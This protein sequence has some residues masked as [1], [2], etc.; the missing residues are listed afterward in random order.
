MMDLSRFRRSG[1]QRAKEVGADQA[2]TEWQQREYKLNYTPTYWQN[3]RRVAR[4]KHVID[5]VPE[6]GQLPEW[7]DR[8]GVNAAYEYMKA[9]HNNAPWWEWNY[10]PNDDLALEPLGQLAAPPDDFLWPNEQ[11]YKQGQQIAPPDTEQTAATVSPENMP[12]NL[13]LW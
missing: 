4:Y 10:L 6:G 11:R 9:R 5:S 3:P 8:D 1:Y 2:L 7:V 12:D 13:P